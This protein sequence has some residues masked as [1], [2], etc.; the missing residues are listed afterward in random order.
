LA[1]P[2]CNQGHPQNQIQN[3]IFALFQRW[4]NIEPSSLSVKVERR[5]QRKKWLTAD[6]LIQKPDYPHKNSNKK[7]KNQIQNIIFPISVWK[8]IGDRVGNHERLA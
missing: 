4:N 3:T 1:A 7:Y 6:A 5:I 8:H 2:A